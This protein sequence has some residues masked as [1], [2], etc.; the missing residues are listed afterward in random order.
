MLSVTHTRAHR[1]TCARLCT[2]PCAVA[3]RLLQFAYLLHERSEF[4]CLPAGQR[5]LSPILFRQYVHL[6]L[7]FTLFILQNVGAAN[8]GQGVFE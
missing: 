1:E 3:D 2:A 6:L 8:G 7:Q 4:E 5:P